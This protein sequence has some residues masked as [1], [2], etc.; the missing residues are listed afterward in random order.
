MIHE[1]QYGNFRRVLSTKEVEN[2]V[3]EANSNP[4]TLVGWFSAWIISV[5][6]ILCF[7]ET[8]GTIFLDHR[9]R[10]YYVQL[11]HE[12][13]ILVEWYPQKGTERS[14]LQKMSVSSV[15]FSN[16]EGIQTNMQFK[17]ISKSRFH[18]FQWICI[19]RTKTE[20]FGTRKHLLRIQISEKGH[21]NLIWLGSSY[22]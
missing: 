13:V 22:S 2:Y 14:I 21:H 12:Y 4:L 3:F 7:S 10:T 9:I 16:Y 19:H 1:S 6:W 8:A 20:N 18:I 5:G 17:K 11:K 15:V